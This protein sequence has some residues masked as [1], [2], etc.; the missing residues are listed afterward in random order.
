MNVVSGFEGLFFFKERFN[1][2]VIRVMKSEEKESGTHKKVLEDIM[3]KN[4]N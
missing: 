3:A 2:H 4:S 1:M